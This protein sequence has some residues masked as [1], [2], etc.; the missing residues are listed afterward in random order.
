MASELARRESGGR[1]LRVEAEVE[2]STWGVLTA[3][4]VIYAFAHLDRQILSL[5]VEP[6][7]R[8]LHISDTEVSLLQGLAFVLFMAVAGVPIGRLV[9]TGKRETIL[10]IG[11]LTWGAATMACSMASSF[12][13]L[14]ALRMGVGVGEAVLTPS[15]HS[16]I[17]EAAPGKRLGLALGIFG[18]G[19]Y[20]GAGLAFI[21]GAF[22]LG[23]LEHLG[24]LRLPWVGPLKVW[25]VVFLAVGAPAAPLA[26][27]ARS[28]P[29]RRRLGERGRAIRP[30]LTFLASRWASLGSVNLTGGF[31][32]AAL[33]A[34]SAW[35]P[36][37]LIRTFHWAAPAAGF[38]YGLTVMICGAMGVVVGGL[39]GDAMRSRGYDSGRLIVMGVAA[40]CAA[41]FVC[42]ASLMAS[43]WRS[44]LVL[45]PASVLIAMTLGLLPAAQQAIVPN[46]FRGATSAWGTLSVNLIALGLGPTLV[47]LATDDLFHAPAAVG[48]SL[49]LVLPI[50]L[51]V[52]AGSAAAG[53][54]AYARSARSGGPEN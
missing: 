1:A 9:D 12:S 54:R 25:Q 38:A 2:A 49:A 45:A 46:E 47:A 27:W 44:L 26:L 19:A 22:I 53:L 3:L 30:S 40:A 32:A 37:Y 13:G 33:N 39:A 11:I 17:A 42:V 14:L 51:I 16:I 21:L 18:V 5:L 50:V 4:V 8:D 36:S 23:S 35:F 6:L 48:C 10:A 52:A 24:A 7:K 15:A 20:I 43:P 41:P 34:T 28:L 29:E 31:A